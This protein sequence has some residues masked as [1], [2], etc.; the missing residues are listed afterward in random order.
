MT[1][2][3]LCE[4]ALW[5]ATLLASCSEQCVGWRWGHVDWGKRIKVGAQSLGLWPDCATGDLCAPV[6]EVQTPYGLCVAG[7]Y[8]RQILHLGKHSQG[9]MC[10]LV[11]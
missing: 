2:I 6:G 10:F 4:F 11:R 3:T 8:G 7:K 9:P 5:S 1:V